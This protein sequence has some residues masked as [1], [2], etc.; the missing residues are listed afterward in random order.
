MKDASAPEEESLVFVT[1]PSGGGRSTA[2]NVLEDMGFET[3][4]M[5]PLS[6]LGRLL[7]S[8]LEKPMALGVAPATR[9]FSVKGF[10]EA[11]DGLKAAAQPA[12]ELLYLDCSP[13][14]LLRRYS[15][16]R[17]RHP[18][19]PDETPMLGI[20]RELELLMPIKERADLLI[21]TSDLSP[22]D[23]KAEIGRWFGS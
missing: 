16:T 1:G 12:P 3:I 4:D 17:R 5:L 19:A 21:D 6:L 11:I 13:E 23:L 18:S 2:I 20:E 8:P 22:H 9:D 10:M 15:E 14:V 7:S